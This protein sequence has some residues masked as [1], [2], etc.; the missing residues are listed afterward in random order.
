[1]L[2]DTERDQVSLICLCVSCTYLIIKTYESLMVF[3]L[4]VLNHTGGL[5]IKGEE[6]KQDV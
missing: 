4:N 1:M 3:P 5:K 6:L 2:N